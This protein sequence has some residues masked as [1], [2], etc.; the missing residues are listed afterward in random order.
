MGLRGPQ[1]NPNSRRGRREAEKAR[2]LA[3]IAKPPVPAAAPRAKTAPAPTSGSPTC[4]DWLS[5][6]Q[7]ALFASLVSDLEAAQ[8][9]IKH[10][11]AHA[12]MMAVQCLSAVKDASD[13][14]SDGDL[15]PK[16][17][18]A[19]LKLKTQAGKDLMQWLQLICATP[20]A[21]ARIG[22]KTETPKKPGFLEKMIAAKQGRKI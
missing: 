2:E 3:R 19:A 8:V 16:D 20:G 22:L 13:L 12:I 7:A 6:D 10:I 17:R 21:R 14:F 4:P 5:P 1:R 18:L 15:D 11:D 9:P